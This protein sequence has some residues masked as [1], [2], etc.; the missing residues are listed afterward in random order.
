M[1]HR[2]FFVL[3]ICSLSLSV[4][5]FTVF[6]GPPPTEEQ[7][8][9][10]MFPYSP[11]LEVAHSSFVNFADIFY[12]DSILRGPSTSER[13]AKW[14]EYTYCELLSA[15]QSALGKVMADIDLQMG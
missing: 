6:R 3:S 13:E 4:I 1:D 9:T 15:D 7:C 12:P 2:R 8:M 11:A 10:H 5:V 14:E